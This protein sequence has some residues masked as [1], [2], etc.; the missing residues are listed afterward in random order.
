MRDRREPHRLAQVLRPALAEIAPQPAQVR[1][2]QRRQGI[3]PRVALVA[4][5][6]G[7]QMEPA[8]ARR[9]AELLQPVAPIVEAAEDAD[10][11]HPRPRRDRLGVEVDRERVLQAPSAPA[12]RRL[13]IVVDALDR[14]R[15]R[16]EV[17]VREGQHD[18]VRRRLGEV[19]RRRGG[20][21]AF[22][23]LRGSRCIG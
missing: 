21:R 9:G 19:D 2:G 10:D 3:E 6:H 12:S 16:R 13:G 4:A 18:D 15:Q 17:A 8:P 1:L 11:H 23:A 22:L 20:D 7:R 14:R 5:R